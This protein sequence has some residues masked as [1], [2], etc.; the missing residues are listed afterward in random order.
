VSYKNLGDAGRD[1]V[2]WWSERGATVRAPSMLNP[3]GIDL[4]RWEELGFPA[5]FSRRQAEIV[6][7]YAAMGIMP[8][9]TCTPYESGN[10]PKMGD[11]LAWSESSAVSFANSYIGRAQTARAAPRPLRRRFSAG[12]PATATTPTGP[13]WPPCASTAGCRDV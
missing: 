9:C 5:D 7:L 11:H 10:L 6:S 4:E 2:A 1:F 12:P 13:G 3:A 8:T